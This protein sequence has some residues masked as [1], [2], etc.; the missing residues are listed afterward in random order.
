VYGFN[1]RTSLI[2]CLYLPLSEHIVMLKSVLSSFLN[3]MK[4]LRQILKMNE[5]YRIVDN[6][7]RKEVK[8]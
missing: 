8:L 7:G 1:P 6:E 3:Y 2:S 4:L 5:K